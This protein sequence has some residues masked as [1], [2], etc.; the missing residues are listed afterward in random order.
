[1][2][3]QSVF[4]IY[5]VDDDADVRISVERLLD[6]AGFH[7]E[8]FASSRLFMDSVP[9]HLETGVLILDLR[10]PG[11]D[12]FTLLKKMQ[13]YG[14]K[15]KIIFITGDAQPEDRDRALRSGAIGFLQKPFQEES[16][17]ELIRKAMREAQ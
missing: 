15:F 4:R 12:G 13:E 7:I 5:C 17:F 11:M 9:V 8:T 2:M 16:L 14:S 1:M 6:S 10:M 3:K